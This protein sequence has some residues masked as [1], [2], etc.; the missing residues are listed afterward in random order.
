MRGRGRQGSPPIPHVITPCDLK[1][2]GYPAHHPPLPGTI[3]PVCAT[4]EHRGSAL[5]PLHF[6]TVPRADDA[7][8]HIRI[9]C[10][11]LTN[12]PT[13]MAPPRRTVPLSRLPPDH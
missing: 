5:P 8:H 1:R 12:P 3:H 4:R 13:R 2:N 9:S 11:R 10:T 6:D 7:V